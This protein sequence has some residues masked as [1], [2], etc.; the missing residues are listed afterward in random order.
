MNVRSEGAAMGRAVT[1]GRAEAI[2]PV[3]RRRPV[4]RGRVGR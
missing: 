4:R 1:G 2:A 3:A